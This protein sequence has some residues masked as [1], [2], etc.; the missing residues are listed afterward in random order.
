MHTT[1]NLLHGIQNEYGFGGIFILGF[2]TRKNI[3]KNKLFVNFVAKK[4]HEN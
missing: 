2:V 1:E 4:E 3:Q